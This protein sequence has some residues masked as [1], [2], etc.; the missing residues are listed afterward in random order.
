MIPGHHLMTGG[1][2][3][4]RLQPKP[5]GFGYEVGY[6]WLN[7]RDLTSLMQ[8]VPQLATRRFAAA[9]YRRADYFRDIV[10]ASEDL[11]EAVM[12]QA[13]QLVSSVPNPSD[14]HRQVLADPDADVQILTPLANYGVFFSPLTLYFIGQQGRWHWMLAEVS[15]TPWNERHYYL[16]PLNPDGVTDYSHAKNFHVSPFNPID[17]IYQ[18]KVYCVGDKLRVSITNVREEIPVF[19][20]WFELVAQPLQAERVQEHLIRFPWQNVQIISR[21]YWQAMR[22]LFKAMPIYSH[23][24]PKDPSK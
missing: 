23:Q 8:Q 16:I 7:L 2:G 14:L 9:S 12:Q 3:H 11:A 13:R 17:M 22:L 10:G 6:F 15:N 5:H 1:V 4:Q 21:I 24:K 18:W 20:A 19:C